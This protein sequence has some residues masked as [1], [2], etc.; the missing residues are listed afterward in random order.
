MKRKSQT[1]KR[2][3]IWQNLQNESNPNI[4]C[5]K[6]CYGLFFPLFCNSHRQKKAY[7]KSGR[8]VHRFQ[9]MDFLIR[10]PIVSSR[11][12]QSR[13][14]T[15]ERTYYRYQ[16]KITIK[17]NNRNKKHWLWSACG[18]ILI[19][20]IY[21]RVE[22]NIGSWLWSKLF[23]FSTIRFSVRCALLLYHFGLCF[24]FY[25]CHIH[26][27]HRGFVSCLTLKLTSYKTKRETTWIVV[28]VSIKL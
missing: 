13:V 14:C 5:I 24:D 26:G 17:I 20:Y 16:R 19:S 2:V 10:M 3:N 7:K 15:I 8:R 21:M 18:K 22:T 11:S 28:I 6:H 23:S 12:D 25:F 1:L 9:S 4:V 27:W